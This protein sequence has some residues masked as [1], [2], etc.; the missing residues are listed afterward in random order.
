MLSYNLTDPVNQ[1]TSY[2]RLH[3]INSLMQKYIDQLSFDE[4]IRFSFN[5]EA[6]NDNPLA[7]FDRSYK[8]TYQDNSIFRTFNS[9]PDRKNPD[10][11]NSDQAVSSMIVDIPQNTNKPIKLYLRIINKITDFNDSHYRQKV[12][13]VEA[14]TTLQK[15]FSASTAISYVQKACERDK[16]SP[17]CYEIPMNL[18]N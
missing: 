11:P 14:Y 2:L 10:H 9:H 17:Q 13:Y 7:Q 18:D 8:N 16:N 15:I 4:F 6:E 1:Q 12:E 5:T 3:K